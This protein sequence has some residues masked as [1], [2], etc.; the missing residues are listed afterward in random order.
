MPHR[1]NENSV[2][3]AKLLVVLLALA[4][5]LNWIAAATCLARGA[6]LE[7]AFRRRRHRRR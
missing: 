5:G 1:R 2:V 3:G 7:P 4:W 6:A